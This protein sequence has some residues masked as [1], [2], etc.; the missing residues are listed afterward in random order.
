MAA[1]ELAPLVGSATRPA[2]RP[3]G[4]QILAGLNALAGDAL[5]RQANR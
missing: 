5:D 2:G 1:A 3:A 4:N